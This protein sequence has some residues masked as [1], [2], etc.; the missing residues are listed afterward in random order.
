MNTGDTAWVLVCPA[1]V[2]IMTPGV[3]LFYGGMARRK[4]ILS[5]LPQRFAIL[6]LVSLQ[7]VLFGYSLAFDPGGAEE[8]NVKPQDFLHKIVYI[9]DRMLLSDHTG[10]ISQRRR[11][12]R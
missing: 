7:R 9:G 12:G 8:K 1:L 11:H 10:E 2:F 5:I 6:C 4:S 3:A